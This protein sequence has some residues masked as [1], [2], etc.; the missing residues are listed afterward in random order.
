MR[1]FPLTEDMNLVA[2]I[3]SNFSHIENFNLEA[4]IED[5]LR[6][7]LKERGYVNILIAGRTGVG[8]SFAESTKLSSTLSANLT[9]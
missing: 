3:T 7:A 2:S 9:I 6:K 8:K 5:A 4:L 1:N